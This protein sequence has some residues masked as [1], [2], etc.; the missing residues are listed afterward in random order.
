MHA[1]VIKCF[2]ITTAIFLERNKTGILEGNY[3][4]GAE[5]GGFANGLL[6]KVFAKD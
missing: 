6:M 3:A 1:V 2:V 5:Q 4:N